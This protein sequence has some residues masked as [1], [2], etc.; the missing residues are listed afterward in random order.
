MPIYSLVGIFIC[1]SILFQ[2][3]LPIELTALLNLE[4]RNVPGMI[5]C[6]LC[7]LICI[8]LFLVSD[9]MVTKNAYNSLFFA[10]LWVELLILLLI[11]IIFVVVMQNKL[12]PILPAVIMQIIFIIAFYSQRKYLQTFTKTTGKNKGQP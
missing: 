10:L 4:N 6:I 1:F 2:F 8:Y 12:I 9:H 7:F 3:N 5:L 11:Y